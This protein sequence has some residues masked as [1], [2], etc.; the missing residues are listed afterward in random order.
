MSERERFEFLCKRDGMAAAKKW[1]QR[2]ADIYRN[3]A[4]HAADPDTAGGAKGMEWA[5]KY[6]LASRDCDKE[7]GL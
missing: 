1:E 7:A 4:L 3:A 6:C 2:T 5:E